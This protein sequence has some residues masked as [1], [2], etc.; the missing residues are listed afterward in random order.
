LKRK[1]ADTRR[2]DA[3][4]GR[5]RDK[6]M[7]TAVLLAGGK[8]RRMGRDKL[9]LP[10]D[11]ST[12]LATAVRRFSEKFD[13]VLLSVD[14]PDRYPDLPAEHV[15]DIY[16]GCGPLAGLHAALAAAEGEGV[17]LAA[18]DLP[19]SDPETAL[20]MIALCGEHEICVTRDACGRFEPL[21]GY[22]GPTVL[23]KAERILA[24]G[25]R[26]MTE[27]FDAA[28]TL[29]LTAEALGLAPGGRMLANMNRPEDYSEL[30]GGGENGTCV[31][32]K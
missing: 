20:K 22:Y 32:E 12:V 7:A 10:Q 29:V 17:F 16:A 14:R 4:R 24:S 9:M 1:Y 2:K 19:F 21:F 18:A 8:S 5:G 15:A 25:G 3:A 11:G 28:D 23:A 31:F 6:K 27:L 13:R 30:L 26:A